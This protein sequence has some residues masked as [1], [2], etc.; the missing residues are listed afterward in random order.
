MLIVILLL[1]ALYYFRT[2]QK[3]AGEQAVVTPKPGKGFA[4]Q[5][6]TPEQ[7]EALDNKTMN[8]ALMAGTIADC[9]KILDEALR[10]ECYDN[11]NLAAILKSG[12]EKQCEKLNDPALKEQCYDQIYFS[13]ATSGL[14]QTLCEKIKDTAMKQN[15]INQIQAVLG[16]T[17]KSETDC[18][19]I[20]D[21]NLKQ[22]CLDNFHFASSI[23]KLDEQGCSTIADL[24]LKG[25]CSQTVTQNIKVMEI[26]KKQ[27][28]AAPKTTTEILAS[29]DKLGSESTRCKDDANYNL[30]FEKMDLG[31]CGKI[32]DAQK[33][34]TCY[35]D[36]SEA[37]NRFYLR[38]AL[39]TRNAQ[40]CDKISADDL[41]TLCKN[42]I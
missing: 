27:A 13:A 39:A 40:L 36:Q 8:E 9:D 23:E 12:D 29:C 28:A 25:R 3:P 22:Q 16:R 6:L 34:D 41:K 5:E 26:A 33:K 31:Y 30:A 19:T 18:A 24:N 32:V 2:L 21:A 7:K 10:K 20:S 14:D 38:Q 42:S 1:G 37:L 15:C 17:A 35:K 11:F 4:T